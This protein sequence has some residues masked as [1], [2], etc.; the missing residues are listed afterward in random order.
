MSDTES[1]V[2]EV[3]VQMFSRYGVKRTSMASVAEAAGVSRQT[4]YAIFK[5][6]DEL[7][8]AAMKSYIAKILLDLDRDWEQSTSPDEIL[9]VYFKHAVYQP[10]EMLVLL[11]D[12]KDLLHGVGEATTKVACDSDVNKTKLLA[13]QLQPY[14]SRLSAVGSDPSA[15]AHFIVTTSNELK[16][17]VNTRRA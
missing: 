13:K 3:A 17:S 8:A 6:K 9:T 12:L 16:Y 11:P 5:S 2:V 7:L 10:F 14:K 4:L 15:I 1:K